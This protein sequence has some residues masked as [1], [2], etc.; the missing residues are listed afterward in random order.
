MSDANVPLG[1][2]EAVGD[3]GTGA[4]ED[5]GNQSIEDQ[6]QQQVEYL[7]LADEAYDR[8][9]KVKVAGEEISV[10][11]REALSGYSREADYTRKTQ[12]LAA[13]RR[14]AQEAELLAQAMQA[15]PGLTV[16]IL[17]QRAGMSVEQ[18]LGLS[19]AQQQAAQQQAE[20]Q[21]DDPLERQLAE[22]RRA[23]EALEQ[24][25]A[26]TEADRELQRAFEGLKSTYRLDDQQ[27]REVVATAFQM[28]LP[29]NMLGTVY[30]S[31]AFRRA[32]AQ[33]QA[34][35]EFTNQQAQQTQQRQQAAA[36]AGQVIGAG[37]GAVGGTTDRGNDG[38]LSLQE[39]IDRAL[40]GWDGVSPL[41]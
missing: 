9:V 2:V 6:Q 32:Q 19:P 22:E 16:Q 4:I 25:F 11:L 23:R 26:Q 36:A 12:E 3:P 5:G 29:P 31:M 10:P 39:S 34:R 8:H 1:G 15:N 33:A 40:A 37:A 20:Q 38:N 28:G 17:A 24:R 21:Y 27:A 18:Y 41:S 35:G 13:Q 14:Q 7:D 30:E